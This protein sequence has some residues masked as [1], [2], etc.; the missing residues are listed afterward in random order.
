MKQLLINT[1][2]SLLSTFL[3]LLFV[4]QVLLSNY[5]T[6]KISSIDK[7]IFQDNQ[8]YQYHPVLG[9]TGRPG[10]T[11]LGPGGEIFSQHNSLGYRSPDYPFVK[12]SGVERILILGDS[13]AY[14]NGLPQ[15]QSISYQIQNTLKKKYPNRRFEFF[16]LG[17]SGYGPDQSYLKYILEGRKL[18][19][20]YVIF[21]AFLD[22]DVIEPM[23]KES[24][25][26][27]KAFFHKE[28]KRLC[29]A[30]VP[31]RPSKQLNRGDLKK[32]LESN[33]LISKITNHKL[34]PF[35][36]TLNFLESR[37]TSSITVST[38]GYSSG[39]NQEIL[40]SK[41]AIRNSLLDLELCLSDAKEP[42][43]LEWEGASLL[44]VRILKMLRQEI[45]KDGAEFLTVLTPNSGFYSEDTRPDFLKDLVNLLHKNKFNLVDLR[46]VGKKLQL[47]AEQ[48]YISQEDRH[49]SAKMSEVAADEIVKSI[50]Q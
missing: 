39:Q 19:P 42:A 31:P 33:S 48:F 26:I 27:E 9:L 12:V 16:N 10:A 37:T 13:Q 15:Q 1:G 3:A 34:F 6:D 17:V 11:L 23:Q 38:L 2:T 40:L 18:E 50:G 28:G 49:L 24:W 20:D 46:N 22:N 30:N 25:G 8:L 4:D 14:G 32:S 41:E 44:F 36:N 29:L 21:I 7:E 35:R 47:S 5:K 45:N 43:W